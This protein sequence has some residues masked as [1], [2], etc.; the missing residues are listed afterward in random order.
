MQGYASTILNHQRN[1]PHLGGNST[2][3]IITHHHLPP[4]ANHQHTTE[5]RTPARKILE[6]TLSPLAFVFKRDSCSQANV[7]RS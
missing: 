5:H 7:G 4:T 2:E 6:H 1:F 3:T